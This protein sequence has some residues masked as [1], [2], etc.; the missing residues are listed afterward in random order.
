[1]RNTDLAREESAFLT[2]GGARQ[3]RY[4]ARQ[5]LR[6]GAEIDALGL[7]DGSVLTDSAY[8]YAVIL[9]SR[10]PKQFVITS[11]RDFPA[12]LADPKGHEVRYYLVSAVGAADAVR[13][14]YP[15]VDEASSAK[16]WL[17]DRGRTLFTL[18]P[19]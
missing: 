19:V 16:V 13:A 1:L 9:A 5:H 6:I 14:A 7:P 12:I 3:T 17:D 10:R 15:T 8:S 2:E 4:L 11:D 18:V